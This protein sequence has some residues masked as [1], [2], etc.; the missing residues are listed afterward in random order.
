MLH[1]YTPLAKKLKDIYTKSD[2]VNQEDYFKNGGSFFTFGYLVNIYDP[3]NYD[4]DLELSQEQMNI[5]AKAEKKYYTFKE[6]DKNLNYSVKT[7]SIY[8]C[9]IS[10]I[11]VDRKKYKNIRSHPVV[12]NLRNLFNNFNDWVICKILG[13]DEFN[14]VLV[15][16]FLFKEY[17]IFYQE[18]KNDRTH[19]GINYRLYGSINQRITQVINQEI[20]EGIKEGI[21]EVL[22]GSINEKMIDIWNINFNISNIIKKKYCI[23]K[24][25]F[26]NIKKYLLNL[27]YQEDKLFYYFYKNNS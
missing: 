19:S 12:Y 21:K 17:K 4:I 8:R 3:L 6:Y 9:R 5:L 15:N 20:H 22:K 18:N 26:I 14:R 7:N 1:K 16:I 11:G 25:K 10:Q 2:F 23:T 13:V 24:F 27:K